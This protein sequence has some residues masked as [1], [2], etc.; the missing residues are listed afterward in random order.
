MLC[1]VGGRAAQVCVGMCCVVMRAG[2]RGDALRDAGLRSDVV[3]YDSICVVFANI[4]HIQVLISV[5]II[6]SGWN[7][8][9]Y[10]K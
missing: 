2:L 5:G 3:H 10:K 6:Y 7:K 4:I 8:N 1:S 9:Q